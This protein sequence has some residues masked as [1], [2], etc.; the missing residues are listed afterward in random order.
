MGET[1]FCGK[2]VGQAFELESPII[3][4]TLHLM[5]QLGLFPEIA[6][7]LFWVLVKSFHF[8]ESVFSDSSDN[9]Y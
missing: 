1:V 5:G 6:D 2:Q 3:T 4:G 7:S 8:N 9:K